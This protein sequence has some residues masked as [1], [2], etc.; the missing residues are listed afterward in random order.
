MSM[1]YADATGAVAGA[2]YGVKRQPCTVSLV[3]CAMAA[4]ACVRACAKLAPSACVLLFSS[5]I[6]LLVQAA[7]QCLAGAVVPDVHC[8]VLLLLL[9]L[10]LFSLLQPGLIQIGTINIFPPPNPACPCCPDPLPQ[11]F[12][13]GL[14]GPPV[15]APLRFPNIHD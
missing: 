7:R 5:L 4:R 10:L 1:L 8:F 6:N 2:P 11:F 12:N 3:C 13:I 14:E 15:Q 9:L